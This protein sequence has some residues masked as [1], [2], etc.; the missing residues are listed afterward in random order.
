MYMSWIQQEMNSTS[1]D[2]VNHF[3]NA[4]SMSAVDSL[5]AMPTVVSHSLGA[6]V[7]DTADVPECEL[8]VP[9]RGRLYRLLHALPD[10]RQH[11]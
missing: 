7:P 3:G 11:P 4:V 6:M 10:S 1:T 8:E 9:V 5:D 2:Q